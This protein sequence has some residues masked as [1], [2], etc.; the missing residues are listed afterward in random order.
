MSNHDKCHQLMLA[1]AALCEE[2][3]PG[4]SMCFCSEVYCNSKEIADR[5]SPLF[6]HAA[7]CE[8]A[9]KAMKD[10]SNYQTHS[11]SLELVQLRFRVKELRGFID[12]I[13]DYTIDQPLDEAIDTIV[14]SGRA[15]QNM[16][17]THV[18][19]AEHRSQIA[20]LEHLVHEAK[21][22]AKQHEEAMREVLAGRDRL[23]KALERIA[24]PLDCGCVPCRG[25]CESPDALKITVEEH[26]EIARAALAKEQQS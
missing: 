2:E 13:A 17:N 6:E 3:L 21:E 15:A 4:G 7:Y 8:L 25:D 26:Q 23:R 5:A 12:Y 19:K 16:D 14:R 24:R 9:S 10:A 18:P 11:G 22:G 20:E 1:L